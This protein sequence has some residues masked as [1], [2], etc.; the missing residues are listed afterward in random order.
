[1]I[2]LLN[3]SPI[4]GIDLKNWIMVPKKSPKSPRIPKLSIINPIKVLLIRINSIPIQKQIVPR[5]LVGLVKNVT[6]LCGPIININPVTN[7]IFPRASK[8]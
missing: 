3:T 7:K 5:T 2:G 4:Y 8:A 6:V 1:M